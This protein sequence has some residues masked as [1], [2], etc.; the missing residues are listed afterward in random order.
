MTLFVDDDEH[1][2]CFCASQD[3]NT[4]HV[5]LL[6]AITFSR[7][8]GSSGSSRAD[9]WKPPAVFKRGGKYF[10]IA[11]RLHGWDPNEARSAVAD[12]VW[13]RGRSS[14]TRASARTRT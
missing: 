2:Y 9:T 7:R 5:V 6:S 13:G 11:I 12:S 8:G 3:N 14:A 4:M 1:A 10:L